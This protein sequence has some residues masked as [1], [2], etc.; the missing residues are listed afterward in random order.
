MKNGWR[1]MSLSDV[2]TFENGDR[3]VNYPSK[4]HQTTSGVPFINAGHLTDSGLDFTTMNYV[5]EERFELLGNGKIRPKDILFCLRGSLGKFASVGVLDRGVIASS[6]VIVRPKD[7]VLDQYLLAYFR[8][9]ICSRMIDKFR[10]GAAQPNLSAQSL[11]RF[12]IPV[13]PIAEQRRIVATL[14]EAFEAIDKVKHNTIKK[15]SALD[16]I[17]KAILSKGFEGKL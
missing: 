17:K 8:S 3:G 4:A 11:K 10:N 15:L 16:E 1:K 9:D 2:A 6:L 5:S 7:E 14:D 12:E 13:P